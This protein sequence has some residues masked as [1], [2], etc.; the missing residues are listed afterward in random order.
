MTEKEYILN[1][2]SNLFRNNGINNI[3]WEKQFYSLL[4]QAGMVAEQTHYYKEDKLNKEPNIQ[5]MVET[6]CK[7]TL[8]FFFFIV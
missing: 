5:R 7:Y 4:A 6:K 2:I 3:E 1:V 8:P